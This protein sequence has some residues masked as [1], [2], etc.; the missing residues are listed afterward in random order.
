[1]DSDK[2]TFR[3]TLAAQLA[4]IAG[5]REL[6]GRFVQMGHTEGKVDVVGELL[7]Y[8]TQDILR[9][10]P[11]ADEFGLQELE[12][13][14]DFILFLRNDTSRGVETWAEVRLRA[15]KLLGYLV[16]QRHKSSS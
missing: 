16:L 9:Y 2:A 12:L 4:A 7:D 1:M 6:D 13:L 8:Y 10:K 14:L 11:F 3:R 5:A 15:V